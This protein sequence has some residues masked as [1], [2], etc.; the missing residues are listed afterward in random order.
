MRISN[1]S[2]CTNQSIQP[3]AGQSACDD[4]RCGGFAGRLDPVEVIHFG[5]ETGTCHKFMFGETV[6]RSINLV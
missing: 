1:I 6:V 5:T 4:G 3:G 2:Y